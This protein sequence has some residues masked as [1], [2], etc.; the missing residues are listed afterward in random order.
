MQFCEETTGTWKGRQ[1]G[2]AGLDVSGMLNPEERD[3]QS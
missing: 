3:A 1:P 2:L